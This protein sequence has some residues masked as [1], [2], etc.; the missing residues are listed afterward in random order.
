MITIEQLALSPSS[1]PEVSIFGAKEWIVNHY[2]KLSEMIM[3]LRESGKYNARPE[4]PFIHRHIFPFLQ[5]TARAA[6][7]LIVAYQPDYFG[8]PVSQLAFLESSV[9]E[10]FRSITNLPS[11]LSSGFLGDMFRIRNL[12]QCIEMKS[13][14]SKGQIFVPY[15]SDR[16]GMKIE[17]RDVSFRYVKES[18]YILKDVNL[19]I[20]PGEIVSIVG[21]N[22]SGNILILK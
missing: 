4:T 19:T 17:L 22:G 6:M 3:D 9:E 2:K 10:V 5:S 12:F 20:E 21:Y 8:I 1:R 11:T 7:Y 16:K 14:V 13:N 15:K 18:P